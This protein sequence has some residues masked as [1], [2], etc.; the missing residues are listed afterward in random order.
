MTP[1]FRLVA[2]TTTLCESQ[3]GQVE[4][5]VV[6]EDLLPSEMAGP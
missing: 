2:G 4:G 3:K 6:L 1:M 5:L